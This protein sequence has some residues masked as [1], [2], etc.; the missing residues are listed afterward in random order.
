HVDARALGEGRDLV[1]DHDWQ[2]AAN[3]AAR[4]ERVREL[5]Q[6]TI[7]LPDAPVEIVQPADAD[8]PVLIGQELLE[9]PAHEVEVGAEGRDVL[10]RAVVEVEGQ[11]TEPPL[12]RAHERALAGGAPL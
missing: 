9:L 3:E 11:P 6:N 7:E 1:V 8:L 4:L 5:A 12:A 2:R 10:Q